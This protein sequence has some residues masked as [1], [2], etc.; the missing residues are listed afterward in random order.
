MKLKMSDITGV[1]KTKCSAHAMY[2]RTIEAIFWDNAGRIW[3]VFLIRFVNALQ[4]CKIRHGFKHAKSINNI[5]KICIHGEFRQNGGG[6]A[7]EVHAAYISS[8]AAP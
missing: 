6:Q 4:F 3:G 8:P 5:D 7:E 1:E 2:L